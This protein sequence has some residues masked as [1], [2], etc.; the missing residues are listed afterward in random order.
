MVSFKLGLIIAQVLLASGHHHMSDSQLAFPGAEGYGATTVGGR[1]GQVLHVT[2]LNDSGAGSLR[3]ALEDVKGPRTVVFDVNGTITLSKQ[4]MLENPFVT[5]AG[6]TAPGDGIVIEG[7]RIRVKADEV[8]VQGLHFRPGD[9]SVGMDPGDRD[10]LMVGT[11]DFQVDHVIIDHNSFEW[12]VDENLDI[13]GRVHDV[14][15][16][17]N[18]IAQGLSHSIHPEGEHSKGFLISNWAGNQSDWDANISVVKNLF[19]DN[20]TRNPEIRAGQHIEVANN[21]MY[22]FGTSDH[23]VPIGS[24]SDGQLVTT[25]NVIGNVFESGPSSTGKP[26]PI[27]IT[28]MATGSAVYVSDN[29]SNKVATDANGNQDQTKLYW[30]SAGLQFVS[31]TNPAFASSHLN[32][33]DSQDVKAYVLAHAGA[34]PGHWDAVD[35]RIIDSAI[36][37]TGK[38]VNSVAQAGGPAPNPPAAPATDT[39]HDGMPDWFESQYHL[40][41]NVFDANGDSDG[42]GYTNLEEYLNG[43]LTGFD[44]G[45]PGIASNGLSNLGT[46]GADVINGGAGDDYLRG[47]DGN[48]HIVGGA[49]FDDINGNTGADTLSGGEGN[50]WVVG[51][52]DDD[53]LSGDNGGDIV[54]G[55]IG[56]DWCDGGAGDD[57]VRGGQDNDV[58]LGQAGNDWLSGDR[59]A[60]TI[61]GGAGADTFHTFGDAGI[62]RVTDFNRAEGDQ[63]LVDPGTRYTVAQ[64]GADVVIDMGGGNQMQLLGV[65]L[66]SLT[67]HWISGA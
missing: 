39:D 23:V 16:S 43:L 2:N 29:I 51:G 12:G 50:D 66:A 7:S 55:N 60:D 22:N 48:D 64:V 52:K 11:T 32:L 4:I 17:N 15:V 18:I 9:G 53:N 46:S 49:G 45:A 42:D 63:V 25:V 34:Q 31:T 5:I 14:T 24:G 1:G 67:G 37:N 41:P 61:S 20:T 40:N 35:Q 6:Q 27:G 65:S 10:G 13:Q 21:Y 8:I 57:I 36:A 44:G 19:A 62:D 28:K 56:N 54:Y 3:W 58:V 30:Q 47:G 38:I 26:I 59:G 33:L